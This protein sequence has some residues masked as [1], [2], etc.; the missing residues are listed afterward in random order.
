MTC[1]RMLYDR[2][3]GGY[4]GTSRKVRK[5]REVNSGL[6]LSLRIVVRSCLRWMAVVFGGRERVVVI[7]RFRGVV[8]R[9]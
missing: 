2:L 8:R 9:V 7:W 3:G 5:E 6:H 1:P 4:E